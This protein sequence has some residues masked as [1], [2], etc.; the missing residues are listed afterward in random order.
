MCLQIV[1]ISNILSL[2]TRSVMSN[3]HPAYED[4]I[5][6]EALNRYCGLKSILLLELYTYAREIGTLQYSVQCFNYDAAHL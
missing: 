4:A 1:S 3:N 2:I 6:Y 5:F